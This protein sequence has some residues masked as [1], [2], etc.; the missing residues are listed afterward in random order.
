MIFILAIIFFTLGLIIGSFLNVVICRI[1]T[2]ESFLGS[3]GGRSACM[4]CQNLL[5]WYELIPLFSFLSLKGRCLSCKTK[6]SIQYPLVELATGLIFSFLFLK[7]SASGGQ[8]IFYSNIFPFAITYAYYATTFSLLVVI[9]VY[10]L[11]HKI[12]PDILSFI[13]G[14]LA[15]AGLFFFDSSGFYIH[16]PSILEFLSGVFIALPFALFWLISGGRWM[17]LGDAKL[18]LGIGWLLGFASA[19]SSLVVAFWSGAVIGVTLVI[20]SKNSKIRRMGVKSEIPFAPFLVF[21]ALLA[22]L[23]SLNFFAL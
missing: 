9:A 15:F 18:A 22:F 11:K 6:I 19:L 16:T 21:G 5:S 13:F 3:F 10:D 8:D 14:A 17:G 7:F 1:N 2:Q 4:S 23:F 20:L 12:I